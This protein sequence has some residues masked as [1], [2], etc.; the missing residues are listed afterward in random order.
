MPTGAGAVN[1]KCEFWSLRKRLA[2]MRFRRFD[3]L[4]TRAGKENAAQFFALIMTNGE[5]SLRVSPAQIEPRG[6]ESEVTDEI[7]A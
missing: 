7:E 5:L 3:F 2:Q 4:R 6:L 1:A